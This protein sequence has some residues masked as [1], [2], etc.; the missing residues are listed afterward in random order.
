MSQPMQNLIVM[1]IPIGCGIA[2]LGAITVVDTIRMHVK[3]V[4]LR[5]Q[6]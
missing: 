2:I 6:R 3:R 4:R 5:H 1:M